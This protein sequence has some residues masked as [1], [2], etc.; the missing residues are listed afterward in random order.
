[1]WRVLVVAA[2]AGPA[3]AEVVADHDRLSDDDGAVACRAEHAGGRVTAACPRHSRLRP[4]R[5]ELLTPIRFE[6]DK[7]VI[8]RES[9]AVLDEVAAILAAHPALHL[10]IQG[11]G[12]DEQD[13]AMRLTDR[14]ARAVLAFLVQRGGIEAA[15]L[16]AQG[17][18]DSVPLYPWGD[19]R[20]ARNV[21]IELHVLP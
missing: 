20:A 9:F 6:L 13:R 14:R 2:L 11:H 16:T 15:R 18:G 12:R 21:R 10:E 19:P 7:D 8:R 17:Y 5:V 3:A 1:M 4:D